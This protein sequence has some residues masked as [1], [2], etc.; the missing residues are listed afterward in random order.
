M[1]KPE[2]KQKKPRTKAV[3]FQGKIIAVRIFE[4]DIPVK[5]E[6]PNPIPNVKTPSRS[7]PSIQTGRRR[8]GRDIRASRHTIWGFR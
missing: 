8:G 4:E 1:D 7:E 6:K 2:E 5:K 3:M